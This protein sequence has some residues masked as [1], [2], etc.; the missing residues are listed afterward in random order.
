MSEIQITTCKELRK[1][2]R[3]FVG[4]KLQAVMVVGPPG[5]SKTESVK[6]AFRK[7]KYLYL[8]GRV[9]ALSLFENL[10]LHRNMPV[11][12]DDTSEMLKDKDA[13]EILRGL[14]E[15]TEQRRISWHTQSR[16]LDEKGLP[17]SFTTNSPVCVI[18]NQ[19]GTGG[20]WPAL[21]SR[22]HRFAVEF[23]WREACR[24]TRRVGWFQDEEILSFAENHGTCRADVRLFT[25]AKEL[26]NTHLRDWRQVF[27]A[28]PVGL[29][30]AD[31]L[32][33]KVFGL[34]AAT[35]GLNTQKLHR[36]CGNN[37]KTGELSAALETLI[38]DG[39]IRHEKVSGRGRPPERFWP[40]GLP[41]VGAYEFGISQE[42]DPVDIGDGLAQGHERTKCEITTSALC[43]FVHEV[44]PP[45]ESSA[46]VVKRGRGRPRKNPLPVNPVGVLLEY[47]ADIHPL[48]LPPRS[49]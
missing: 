38:A 17:K 3:L 35:P 1:I 30:R 39:R 21:V 47:Q 46:V 31:K 15:H 10:Y 45:A 18:S 32:V 28:P 22:C 12:L 8:N 44:E 16:I 48:T 9:S 2:A 20:V 37:L 5:Q 6:Q 29:S 41:N 43:S 27:E 33:V 36:G 23:D 49:I 13:Q 14:M 24:E 19:I 11:V 40:A 26:K 34:V 4:G 25:R 7:K 42:T